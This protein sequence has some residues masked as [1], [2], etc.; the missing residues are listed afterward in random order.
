V[1][2]KLYISKD[3]LLIKKTKS[4]KIM[5]MIK[6]TIKK[7]LAILNALIA[8]FGIIPMIRVA[9]F[10]YEISYK[11]LC[12]SGVPTR[13]SGKTLFNAANNIWVLGKNNLDKLGRLLV[14]FDI[15]KR[16]KLQLR[17]AVKTEA[18]QLWR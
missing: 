8:L 5:I 18:V 12:K 2:E 10:F 4:N 16:S 15:G 1:I 17:I 3:G 9:M 11:G 7:M 13:F 6:I 14:A